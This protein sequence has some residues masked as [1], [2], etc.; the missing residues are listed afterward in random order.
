R[1]R[2]SPPRAAARVCAGCGGWWWGLGRGPR[3]AASPL[4][5]VGA[6]AATCAQTSVT[7]HGWPDTAHY[8]HAFPPVDPGERKVGWARTGW[9]APVH[10]P[11]APSQFP[12]LNVGAVVHAE[13]AGEL[14]LALGGRVEVRDSRQGRNGVLSLRRI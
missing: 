11:P 4:S 10:W 8:A 2:R 1:P 9:H 3:R 6:P 7:G 5:S 14:V 13:R 12:G